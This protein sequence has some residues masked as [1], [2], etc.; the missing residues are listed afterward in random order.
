MIRKRLV[1]FLND[2]LSYRYGSPRGFIKIISHQ[3]LN[4]IG[5]YKN[6][7]KIEWNK[8]ERLVFVCKGNICRSAFAEAV[9]RSQNLETA[10]CGIETDDGKPANEMAILVGANKGYKLDN[11]KTTKLSSFVI[12]KGDLLIAME[13]YQAR[14]LKASVIDTNTYTLMGLWGKPATPYI[15]DPYSTSLL[16]FTNCFDYIEETVIA[17]KQKINLNR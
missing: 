14:Y 3:F 7:K 4:Y 1:K 16:Y 12:K 9:A 8:V 5:L 15:N 6:Y 2:R 13:P 17:I 10:S 11:H